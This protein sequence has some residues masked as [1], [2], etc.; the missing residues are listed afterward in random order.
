MTTKWRIAVAMNILHYSFFLWCLTAAVFLAILEPWYVAL[1]LNVFLF[2][3]P[4]T[5]PHTCIFTLL[6]DSV[7]KQIGVPPVPQFLDG[8]KLNS[9]ALWRDAYYERL[10]RS[11]EALEAR[12]EAFAVLDRHIAQEAA[13]KSEEALNE[14]Q[15]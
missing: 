15:D 3:L 1:P 11:P 7:R 5:V 2:R 6:E 13:K 10:K 8:M 9:V 14:R 4:M 12:R